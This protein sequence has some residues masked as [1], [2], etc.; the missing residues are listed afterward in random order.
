MLVMLAVLTVSLVVLLPRPALGCSCAWP[1]DIQANTEESRAVFVGTLVEVRGGLQG[2]FGGEAV[3]RFQVDHWVK[4]GPSDFI[5]V[6]A[7]VGDGGNCGLSMPIGTRTGMFVYEWEGVLTSSSCST[8]SPEMLLEFVDET[9]TSETNLPW[10]LFGMSQMF[11][12]VDEEGALITRL[13]SRTSMSEQAY[14]GRGT[15]SLCPGGERFAHFTSATVTTWDAKGLDTISRTEIGDFG[16]ALPSAIFCRNEDASIVWL[17]VNAGNESWVVETVGSGETVYSS[18]DEVVW[19]GATHLITRSYRGGTVTRV[20]L[21]TLEATTLHETVQFNSYL[22]IVPNPYNDTTAV[23]QLPF[24]P[25]VYIYDGEGRLLSEHAVSEASG[26]AQWA[27]PDQLLMKSSGP[28]DLLSFDLSTGEMT[29]ISGWSGWD[30]LV[31]HGKVYGVDGYNVVVMDLE[32]GAVEGAATLDFAPGIPLM[33]LDGVTEISPDRTVV[34][35]PPVTPEELG[36]VSGSA[37][38][39]ASGTARLALMAI[40]GLVLSGVVASLVRRRQGPTSN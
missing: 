34:T 3:F 24:S 6:H 16:D 32:S 26:N 8:P 37:L 21:E 17:V 11:W 18:N 36:S 28:R 33:V 14:V 13:D 9:R 39:G 1:P 40:A 15:T 4:G 31:D 30:F 20:D 22:E 35:A 5:E 7:S 19:V 2:R 10:L 27:G 23:F 25:T 38:D 12:V 29:T